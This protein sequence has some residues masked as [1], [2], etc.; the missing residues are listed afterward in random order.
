MDKESKYTVGMQFW[1]TKEGDDKKKWLLN[2]EQHD[3]NY[4]ELIGL[5]ALGSELYNNLIKIGVIQA[6]AAGFDMEAILAYLKGETLDTDKPT[7]QKPQ[8][9]S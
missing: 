7:K 5:Q 2:N 8:M 4:A 9:R 3:M 1:Y 6:Q